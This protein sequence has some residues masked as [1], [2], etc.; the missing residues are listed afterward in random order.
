MRAF[1]YR[2]GRVFTCLLFIVLGGM[3]LASAQPDVIAPS[4]QWVT[5]RGDVL[6]SSEERA[7]TTTLRDY[8]D[9]TS[10]QIIIVTIPSLDG[11]DI[12]SYATEL[13]Q[14]WG[15]GQED[16][17]NG[18]V[19]LLS[20]DDRRVFIATGFG[21]EGAV[22]DIVAGRIVRN[23]MIPAFREG[24]YYAGFSGAVDAVI[25]AAAGE[26][27]A[28][29]VAQRTSRSNDG[30]DAA[31]VFIL[32]I[33]GYFVV[34]GLRKGGRRGGPGGPRRRGRGRG[35]GPMIIWGGGGFGGGRG[36]FG[37][38]GFGG[39]GFGG[40]GGSFGGGGAGGSW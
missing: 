30:V 31:T 2:A 15:V 33:I 24:N 29:E 25:S 23:I 39:G 37:G 22:P 7:L 8:A 38:G 13:G 1:L 3:S 26:Y 20:R 11:A 10:T 6:S 34:S 18:A 4:G 16:R 14:Q 40:G 28:S 21:L 19:I 12:A 35:M 32:L 27:E 36:G 5:D 17:D 9:S